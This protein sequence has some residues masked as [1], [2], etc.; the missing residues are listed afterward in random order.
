[1]RG[2]GFARGGACL[3]CVLWR[4]A[5]TAAAG[6]DRSIGTL[7]WLLRG[8]KSCRPSSGPPLCQFLT[9]PRA[10]LSCQRRRASCVWHDE[11]HGR[12]VH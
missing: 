3:V 7:G 4:L 10:L 9:S 11:T 1:M 6:L 5:S 8:S 12:C 2:Q